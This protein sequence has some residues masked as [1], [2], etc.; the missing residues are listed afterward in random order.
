MSD[1]QALNE[2]LQEA[3]DLA[4]RSPHDKT[5]LSDLTSLISSYL[6]KPLLTSPYRSF[7]QG[8]KAFFNGQYNLALKH[9]S[10]AKEVPHFLFYCHRATAFVY[11]KIG[12]TAEAIEFAN[13]AL[14]LRLSDDLSKNLLQELTTAPTS[15]Q[16]SGAPTANSSEDAELDS[17]GISLGKQ[18]LDDLNEIF[19][20]GKNRTPKFD[21]LFENTSSSANPSAL[22]CGNVASDEDL[23]QTLDSEKISALEELLKLAAGDF[24]SASSADTSA[25]FSKEFEQEDPHHSLE[26]RIHSFQ[27]QQTKLMQEYAKRAQQRSKLETNFLRILNGWAQN[28][29][30]KEL[31]TPYFASEQIERQTGG[32]YLRWNGFGI[33]INPGKEFLKHFHQAG[34]YIQDIDCVIVTRGTPESYAD[35]KAIYDLNYELN[36]VHGQLHI[37]NYYLNQKAYHS[38]ASTLKPSFKQER[39]TVHCLELYIDSPD[40]EYIALAPGIIFNYFHT[41][42]LQA[43]LRAEE[44]ITA[45]GKVSPSN[46]GIRLE[47]TT[48]AMEGSCE[49]AKSLTIGWLSGIPWSPLLTHYLD[50]CQVLIAGFEKTENQDYNRIQYN[51]DSLG[52]FGTYS[53]LEAIHPQ[54]LLC[55]EFNGKAGDIR[56]EV[57]KKMR[58]DYNAPPQSS[59]TVLPGDTDFYLDLN[60]LKVQCTVS[61]ALIEPS[62]IRVIKSGNA[63]AT[64][65]YL[66]PSCLL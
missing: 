61:K 29:P 1:Q 54:L 25:L 21:I 9:Y 6:E 2:Y 48:T 15:H 28:A 30:N 39:R 56:L 12:K 4:T 47:L 26:K 8:E 36:K 22:S 55:S 20:Y 35:I 14:E 53:L 10:L 17:H 50:K 13:K 41:S 7:F 19:N 60:S 46:L 66:A 11:K 59:T 58:Q 63:F 24:P 42:S 16:M 40:I 65:Q 43:E 31:N 57:I 62:K 18:E 32:Y 27:Q 52:Y 23:G 49:Q 38:L 33:A 51:K 45:N 5:A 44:G 3:E 34:L 37:I 64:L